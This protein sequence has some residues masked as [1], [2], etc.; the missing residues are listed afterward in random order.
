MQS[1]PWSQGG[2]LVPPVQALQAVVGAVRH[3]RA[4]YGVELGRRIPARIVIA[5]AVLRAALQEEAAVLCSL[6]KLDAAQAWPCTCP[7]AHAAANIGTNEKNVLKDTDPPRWPCQPAA[8]LFRLP[9]P[10]MLCL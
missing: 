7:Q 5:D 9:L 10:Q 2:M 6:A 3:A 8:T 4:E 1:H